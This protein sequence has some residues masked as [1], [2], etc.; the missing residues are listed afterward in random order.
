MEALSEHPTFLQHYSNYL[1]SES[2][3]IAMIV[4]FA[5]LL[6]AW[7][8][9][10]RTAEESH[11]IPGCVRYGLC[12]RSNLNAQHEANDNASERDEEPRVAALFAYP[13]KSCRGVELTAAEVTGLG[14]KHDRLFSFAQL[15]NN[16]TVGDS[17]SK[18]EENHHWRFITQRDRPQMAL[19]TTELWIP[20]PRSQTTSQDE[21]DQIE[22]WTANGGCL[23]VRFPQV[24]KLF[25]FDVYTKT[26]TFKLPLDPTSQ[27]ARHKNYIDSP[28]S[29]WKDNP[30]AL[31]I[32]SEISP[33]SFT[34]L[35]TFLGIS[36]P[37]A[38]FRVDHSRAI[39]RS[40]P[41]DRSA[42]D[43]YNVGFADA[44][45]LS[46]L[47]LA[48]VRAIDSSLP[49]SSKLKNDLSALRFRANIYISGPPA[50][51][52]DTWKRVHIGLAENDHNEVQRGEYHIACRTARC[53]LPNV[54]PKSG[55]RDK[56]EPFSTLKR[57]RVV[58]EGAK[59]HSSLGLSAL[60]LFARGILRVG[61]KIEVQERGVHVY[62]KMFQ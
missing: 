40:L 43:I 5:I 15:L 29:I 1:T 51:T 20:D 36:K 18:V 35:K 61:E 53:T 28:L 45:P 41:T 37:L 49:N 44:F 22:D 7:T 48:S 2:G 4:L 8:E 21:V 17:K 26:I 39:T 10:H 25:G 24:K 31:N 19:I 56:S 16:K 52:E 12:D 6:Y 32:T 3:L 54:D 14:L 34:A 58:D 11:D 62:E 46:F 59:P 30:M 47:N 60:P 9:S 55:V 57:T 33:A 13:I 50:F 38:L 23:I 27:R 42:D